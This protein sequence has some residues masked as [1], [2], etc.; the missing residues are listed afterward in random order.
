MR[1]FHHDV[2]ITTR[3]W[4][5][6]GYLK[7][8]AIISRQG[9]FE[10]KS[11]EL[12]PSIANGAGPLV[13]I[14]RTRDTITHPGTLSSIQRAP[15][16]M[17]HPEKD[18]TADTW[19]DVAVGWVLGEP[20]VDGDGLIQADILITDKDAAKAVDQ[21][22]DQLSV[23]Y[24]Y[25]IVRTDTGFATSGPMLSNHIAIVGKGRAGDR[26]RIQD[27]G[28]TE[29]VE[30]NE[31]QLKAFQ[32]ATATAVS[33]AV[34]KALD[35]A[36]GKKD[37]AVDIGATVGAAMAEALKP[38]AAQLTSMAD[39]AKQ[40][41]DTKDQAAAAVKLKDAAD[42]LVEATRAEERK[43][44][45]IIQDATPLLNAKGV[46]NLDAMDSKTILVTA[47][48]DILPDAETR[49]EDYLSGVLAGVAKQG[50]GAG[51]QPAA[52]SFPTG[53]AG[54]DVAPSGSPRDQFI[55]TMQ[56]DFMT[57]LVD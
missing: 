11:S 9:P 18:V 57:T 29:E 28:G 50:A 25:D 27:A 16:T 53:V 37:T 23:G 10:Y 34:V 39:A 41:K 13:T 6:E 56:G 49:S 36:G 24:A 7:A 15:I 1:L 44:F 26:V 12:P 8:G 55:S 52:R 32:A 3:E 22:T 19:R 43:R 45:A 14:E 47:L 46:T 31:E 17:G 20:K 35:A 54:K 38:V 33:E 42:K 48:K 4:T 40:E 2:L 30:M 21:G 51:P 5:P